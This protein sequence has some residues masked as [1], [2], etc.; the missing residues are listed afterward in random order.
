MRGKVNNIKEFHLW[1]TD[2]FSTQMAGLG[3]REITLIDL[4]EFILKI[5]SSLW[6]HVQKNSFLVDVSSIE[7]GGVDPRPLRK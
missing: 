5:Y 7:G 1:K 6:E 2:D 4:K 3:E